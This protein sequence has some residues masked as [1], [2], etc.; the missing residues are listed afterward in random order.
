MDTVDGFGL[1]SGQTVLGLQRRSGTREGVW[2]MV[3]IG[4]ILHGTSVVVKIEIFLLF[5]FRPSKLRPYT[6][7]RLD[8][9]LQQSTLRTRSCCSSPLNRKRKG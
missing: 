4:V 2:S 8:R 1:D 9:T 6:Y 7:D 5:T 3:T